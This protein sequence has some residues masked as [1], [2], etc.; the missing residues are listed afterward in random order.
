MVVSYNVFV[1]Q[2][3]NPVGVRDRVHVLGVDGGEYCIE[4]SVLRESTMWMQLRHSTRDIARKANVVLRCAR[5][6][7]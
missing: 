2:D 3:G 7:T 6:L 5:R 1:F 4:G